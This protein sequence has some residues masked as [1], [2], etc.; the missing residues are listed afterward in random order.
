MSE[1]TFLSNGIVSDQIN[2]NKL[3]LNGSE[4]T[5]N[6]TD[7]FLNDKPL[8]ITTR[9]KEVV[10]NWLDIKKSTLILAGYDVRSF[11]KFKGIY[12]VGGA[13]EKFGE[14]IQQKLRKPVI[15]ASSDA[16]ENWET[17][18][19]DDNFYLNSK[20][21]GAVIKF[22][23]SDNVILAIIGGGDGLHGSLLR[24]EDGVSW[25]K[26]PDLNVWANPNNRYKDLIFNGKQFFAATYMEDSQGNEI[27]DVLFSNP[28][29]GFVWNFVDE[30]KKIRTKAL[31]Y[32]DGTIL[33]GSYIS[34]DFGRTWVLNSSISEGVLWNLEMNQIAVSDLYF[35]VYRKMIF[36]GE[37]ERCIFRSADGY[38]WIKVNLDNHVTVFGVNDSNVD[39]LNSLE[40]KLFFINDSWL[41][42]S[43]GYLMFVSRDDGFNWRKK[44]INSIKNFGSFSYLNNFS[45]IFFEYPTGVFIGA[46]SG[47][48]LCDY[49]VPELYLKKTYPIYKK[50]GNEDQLFS[51]SGFSP[52]AI[53]YSDFSNFWIVGGENK[54]TLS[55][56][57]YASSNLLDWSKLNIKD[58]N[59]FKSFVGDPSCDKVFGITKTGFYS[60]SLSDQIEVNQYPLPSGF[61]PNSITLDPNKITDADGGNNPFWYASIKLFSGYNVILGGNSGELSIFN[62]SKQPFS[63][64]VYNQKLYN[65]NQNL[66]ITSLDFKKDTLILKGSGYNNLIRSKNYSVWDSGLNGISTTGN[67]DLQMSKLFLDN[68]FTGEVLIPEINNS[69]KNFPIL[70]K[71]Y[72]WVYLIDGVLYNSHDSINWKMFSTV[73]V[74]PIDKLVIHPMDENCLITIPTAS[75]GNDSYFINLDRNLKLSISGFDSYTGVDYTEMKAVRS[76]NPNYY[77]EDLTEQWSFTFNELYPEARYKDT[78]YGRMYFNGY[79]AQLK[80]K[81]ITGDSVYTG[82]QNYD[83]YTSFSGSG[84]FKYPLTSIEHFSPYTS[85]YYQSSVYYTEPTYDYDFFISNEFITGA[86]VDIR[87]GIYSKKC[88]NFETGFNIN[89]LY[90]NDNIEKI[91]YIGD[92]G[93]FG[94]AYLLPTKNDYRRNTSRKI[95]GYNPIICSSGFNGISG[96][97]SA[98][99]ELNTLR[100]AYENLRVLTEQLLSGMVSLKIVNV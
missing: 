84:L 29:D 18:F 74:G 25:E 5:A 16:Y 94:Q 11:V 79:R 73:N 43:G 2:L 6:E 68:S 77:Y 66:D 15:L 69:T 36:N 99:T 53:Y 80:L 26:I 4:L 10:P 67:F 52:K 33:A 82:V 22:A 27:S 8:S 12:L 65:I 100:V 87:T 21:G 19:T 51:I 56:E 47:L 24:S 31:A 13:I 3:V 92:S 60:F 37:A 40:Y 46:Q 61:I 57:C 30:S 1:T 98:L 81:G 34:F 96:N 83:V 75:S 64:I 7:L 42:I 72:G 55:G 95:N 9:K 41:L 49:L 91:V 70:T 45:F 28:N 85:A 89:D 86:S 76:F 50:L 32:K 14:N 17:V 20:E 44:E 62:F 58:K 59:G 63:G 35:M 48:F 71:N 88:A 54:E 90:S 93:N 39:E 78:N 23:K 38:N 97:L